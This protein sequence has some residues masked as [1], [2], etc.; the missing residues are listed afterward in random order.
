[1]RILIVNRK[2]DKLFI[3]GLMEKLFEARILVRLSSDYLIFDVEDITGFLNPVWRLYAELSRDG[4]GYVIEQ[5][6]FFKVDDYPQTFWY[7]LRKENGTFTG[8]QYGSV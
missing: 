4:K 8:I 5:R 3:S 1:M 2:S 7:E 6:R